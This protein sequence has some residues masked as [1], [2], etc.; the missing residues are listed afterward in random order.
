MNKK[1]SLEEF[2][3]AKIDVAKDVISFLKRK[4]VPYSMN[5][6]LIDKFNIVEEDVK[7][8]TFAQ[9]TT[10]TNNLYSAVYRTVNTNTNIRCKKIGRA[11]YYLWVNPTIHKGQ[12]IKCKECDEIAI[13]ILEGK[14]NDFPK[15]CPKCKRSKDVVVR[16]YFEVNK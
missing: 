10:E 1:I 2:N 4:K 3:N 16:D 13:K 11:K 6:I 15:K 5:G 8:K 14:T 7:G 9:R 12:K